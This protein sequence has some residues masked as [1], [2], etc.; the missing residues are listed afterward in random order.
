MTEGIFPKIDGDI[1]YASEVNRFARAGGFLLIGSTSVTVSS[2]TGPQVVGSWLIPA[3]ILSDP[4]AIYGQI[5]INK[6]S[7]SDSI[8]LRLSGTNTGD[9]SIGVGSNSQPDNFNKAIFEGILPGFIKMQ[10]YRTMVDVSTATSNSTWSI[11]NNSF[12]PGSEFVVFVAGSWASS[13][14]LNKANVQFY[15]G[16]F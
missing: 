10:S 13:T 9:V 16:S 15:R 11:E 8:I 7:T 4:C 3:N 6:T 5:S 12:N 2:G 14:S 1:L